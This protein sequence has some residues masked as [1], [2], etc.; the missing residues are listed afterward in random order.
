M[1]R[2]ARVPHLLAVSTIIVAVI[3]VGT[4][5]GFAQRLRSP[6]S[7]LVLGTPTITCGTTPHATLSWSDSAGSSS[8]VYYVMSKLTSAKQ[9]SW[10]QGSP[11]GDVFTADVPVTNNTSYDFAIRVVTS[12]T[13]DSNVASIAVNCP[14][15]DTTAP[16]V[17]TITSAVS[18]SCSQV[19]LAWTTSTDTGGSG[20]AGYNV[21]RNNVFVHRVNAPATTWSDTG[22]A[23][24]LTYS[25]TVT[26]IDG[27]GNQSAK[28]APFSVTTRS[29]TN[30]PP[31]ANAGPDQT[32][33]TLVNVS[34]NGSGSSDPDGSIASYAWN[35]GDGATGSGVAP[36]HSYSSAAVYTVT[37]TVTDNQGAAAQDTMLVTA[38]NRPPTANAGA[39]QSGTAGIAISFNGSGSSDLDGTITAYNWN[40][41]DG[42]TGSGVTTSH[43]YASAGTYTAT[44]TV[45]DNK[46]ATGS[47]TATI[48]IGSAANQPPI[49]N[50]GADQSALTLVSVTFNGSASSDPDG[51]IASYAW[52][53]GDGTTG[54]GAS[55]SHSYGSAG[56]YTVTLTVT[57]NKGATATDTAIAT[58]ANRPPVAAAGADF[59]TPTLGVVSFNGSGSTD[60]DGTITAY[61]WNFG[62][63]ATATGATPT[64]GFAHA[65]TYTVTLTVTDNK[66]ATGTD[67][68]IA[69]ITNRAPTANA[70]PDQTVTVNTATSFSGAGS[71]DPDGSI[72]SYA[73]NWGDGTANGS[74][75]SASHTFT[76]TGTKTVT[77]TV[78][79]NNGATATDTAVVTVNAVTTSG[80]WAKQISSAGTDSV[81]A[82]AHDAAGNIYAAGTFNGSVT[83]GSFPLT[84]S[85]YTSMFVA[86]FRADGSVAWADGAATSDS[87]SPEGIAV[88]VN[89]NVDVVGMFDD[90]VNFGGGPLTA[91]PASQTGSPLDMFVVQY[92]A[93]TGAHQWSKRFGGSY[94][95]QASAV[96]V[97]GSG[98]VYF[99]GFFE[100]VI[101]FGGGPLSDP[102]TSDL[103][104]FIAKFTVG[105]SYVWAK[106]WTNTGNDRGYGI[107]VDSSG[108]V[109]IGGSFSNGIN[110]GGGT[111]GSA[112]GMVDGFIA[113][114]N[115]AGT[116]RWQRQFGDPN[117]NEYVRG[118]AV[119]G[120]GNV[121][122]AATGSSPEDMG[123]GILPPLGSSDALVAE[124]AGADG[125][126][127][128]AKRVG[129]MQNDYASS[130]AIDSA[131]NVYLAGSFQSVANFGVASLTAAGNDDSFIEKFSSTGSAAWVRDYG[132]A[133]ADEF[134]SVTVAPDGS[135]IGGGFFY[136]TETIAGT[137]LTAPGTSSD[138]I[139]VH[140][141]P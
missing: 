22:L 131:N 19:D 25:Y 23:A 43:A 102:Y 86:K 110:F 98:N 129:G 58:I 112:N 15:V 95:D 4:G 56:V 136:G 12:V 105:G 59:T 73:W 18:P 121:A 104:V 36:S 34:F 69:T 45:T 53:F 2:G 75:V 139:V 8:A 21:Y 79:D 14:T 29:C 123:G 90:T 32:V 140:D 128:W 87:V 33:Q 49:A 6:S 16:S 57:D 126:Y 137:T 47:D 92:N 54:S 46:G 135:P 106:N 118:L 89:G 141:A 107:G 96:A 83:I 125:S 124:Y 108:N 50:A 94:T 91:T 55:A 70:G 81:T 82:V 11:L 28:S 130:V 103:D 93:G 1:R 109:T 38:L 44:L 20:L 113:S 63:G 72:S 78:T 42:A 122:I 39:D 10:S 77:L 40:F 127:R 51:S 35:F 76:T 119:D 17:P 114:F 101:D 3:A 138:G 71:S 85:G 27:A 60:A 116:Y 26:A 5:T 41:G 132:G 68:L 133:G 37:L 62:D 74:G 97:D 9:N 52:N 84:G 100:N 7:S 111:L 115:T 61:N 99:T 64:H 88:D 24:S 31:I 117:G 120:S 30:T 65:G 134:Y 13:R 80:P 48:T 67:T 66:G